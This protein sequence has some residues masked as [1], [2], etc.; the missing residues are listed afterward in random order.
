[1]LF[2]DDMNMWKKLASLLNRIWFLLNSIL[3]LLD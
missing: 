3:V 2:I 1:M